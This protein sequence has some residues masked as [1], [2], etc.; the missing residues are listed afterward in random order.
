MATLTNGEIAHLLREIRI[1]MEFAGEPFFKF[2][3]YERAAET[4]ENAPALGADV[5]LERLTALPGV[6]KTIAG[7]I[8]TLAQTGTDPYL[9][10]LRSKYP[11]TL[12][13][14]LG[15]QG[16][17]MKTAQQLYEKLGIASLADLE[18]ALDE[19]TLV[20]FPRLGPKSIENIR[21][22]V[23]SYKG[24]TRRTPLGVALPIAHEVIAYLRK[25]TDAQNLAPA[26]S[27]RRQEP[28]VGD[29]D[30][31]CTSE[32][33]DE[34]VRAFTAWER[35]EAVLAEGPTKASIWLAG[36]LQIDLRVLPEHLYGNLL[37][38]FT[39]S[40][41]HNIQFRELAVRKNLRVSENG[42]VDLTDG[43]TIVCRTEEEVYATLGMAY[44]PPEMRLGVGEIDAAREGTLPRVVELHDLR[45]DFHMHCT[46]SDGRDSLDAMVAACAAR[47]YA[48]H[49]F[50]D[51]SWGR[52]RIGLDPD[53]L[54]KQR[55]EVHALG[56]RYGIRTLCSAE[57]D[58][59]ADG[60]LDYED[61]I[62]AELDMVVASVHSAFNQS[63]D[64][65]TARLIRACENPYV[66]IIGHP[67]GRNVE[68]FAGYE[69]DHDA[70]FAAAA[71][72]G[73]ALEI[74]GQPSRLDLPSSLAHRARAFGVTFT[75][76]SDAHGVGQLENVAYAVGQA[77]R[78]WITPAEVLNTRPVEEVI[79]FV[80]AKRSRLADVHRTGS[81]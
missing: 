42:I 18:R 63:R 24:R 37:Q 12:V 7:R 50:S 45:G 67:T 26:G 41:E 73:T 49:A 66:T 71:R 58:I 6:G 57:V 43:R 8:V 25:T 55:E 13:E 4:L 77:R 48:Y 2:M 19:G 80:E 11:S 52:G 59:R 16:V 3:A 1:L 56:D 5:D 33:A 22:G 39:G 74:D 75:C 68:T 64:E 30:I 31:V 79:A 44:I 65:M 78:A 53:D 14:V 51:H 46:Y 54:R 72:T 35:A 34:V 60:S 69:F 62:L 28:T 76:D 27:V 17:G 70:V 23:L 10:E 20:G 36:G 47:G 38:H 9:D 32:N 61:A 40:R 21:R 15:V 29:V 81:A